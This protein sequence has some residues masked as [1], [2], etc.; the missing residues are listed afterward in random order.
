MSAVV[1]RR[2]AEAAET[3]GPAETLPAWTYDNA[4]FFQLERGH[5]LLNNWQIVGHISEL[6]RPGD[7][8]TLNIVGERALVVRDA[9]GELHAFYNTCRHRA[10]AVVNGSNGNCGHALRCP[11]HGWTYDLQGKLKAIPGEAS[12]PA[13]DKSA[14]GLK[15][16]DLETWQGFVF[17][18]F[19]SGGP[20]VAERM[21]PYAQELSAY[22]FA[23]MEPIGRP[24]T[25]EVDVDWKNVMDNFLEGY[26][27][28]TGHPG[29]YRLFGSR[30]DV[31]TRPG[32][33]SRAM[34]WMRDKPS[35]NWSE[36]HY[37]K[38]LPAMDHLPKDR[39]RAWTYYTLLPNQALDAY[40]D[41]VDFF[42]ILPLAPGRTRM[43]GRAYG[44]PGAS[45][46]IRA[47]RYLGSRINHLVYL[48]DNDLI[49]SVQQGLASES[50]VAGVLSEKE[51][52]VLQLHDMVRRALPVARLHSPPT[53][54][55]MASINSSM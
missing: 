10:A 14:F 37:Q 48:E 32:D 25:G 7:F 5:L 47:T 51:T 17:V 31:E 20:S 39:Q 49:T 38:L 53:A 50:Y 19:R 54:G 40:P 6:R 23:E 42:H 12:F 9:D 45:R 24:W 26:H 34:H 27:V 13:I 8:L 22:R 28:P 4:E 55:T 30:Y 41:R 52:C 46:E 1:Q 29:L 18:R 11:Y 35:A 21:A 44:L 43:R 2:I 15:R 36:R 33:V 16:I 3:I